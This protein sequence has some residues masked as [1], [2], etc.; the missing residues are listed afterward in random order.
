MKPSKVLILFSLFFAANNVNCQIFTVSGYIG[1][2]LTKETLYNAYIINQVNNTVVLSNDKGYYSLSAEKGLISLIYSY[3]GYEPK[4]L[5][6]KIAK[7]TLVDIYLVPIKIKEVTV[8][9]NAEPLFKQALLGKTNFTIKEIESI[10][11]LAGEPDLM[12]SIT[13]IAGV[14]GGREGYSNIY[15]RGGDRGQNLILL[16]GVKLYNTNHLGGFMSLFNSDIIKSVDIY[17]GGF[18]AGY[19]G[20]ASSVIYIQSREGNK[21]KLSGKYS[22]GILQSKV[23]LEGPIKSDKTSFLFALRGSYLDILTLPVRIKYLNGQTNSILGYT[24]TDLNFKLTQNVNNKRKLTLGIYSGQ[25]LM[26][27]IERGKYDLTSDKM[28]IVNTAIYLDGTNIIGAKLFSKSQLI[29]SSYRNSYLVSDE[30]ETSVENYLSKLENKSHLNEVSYK[31]QLSWYPANALNIRGGFEASVY[32]FSPSEFHVRQND[33]TNNISFDTIY[34][35]QNRLRSLESSLYLESELDVSNRFTINTGLRATYYRFNNHSDINL[36]PRLSIRMLIAEKLSAKASFT[37]MTQNNL[38]LISNY[39]GFEREVWL[40]ATDALPG[41]N[42]F[43]YSIGIFGDFE[44]IHLEYGIEAYIKE[45]SE[46]YYFRAPAEVFE[47]FSQLQNYITTGGTGNSV[48][49]EITAMFNYP[50]LSVSLAYTLAKTTRR[51]KDINNN[52]EFPS[53]FDRRHDLSLQTSYIISKKYILNAHFIYSSGT[54][55]T[56]PESYSPDN[57][58]YY[59]YFNYGEMNNVRLPDYHRLDFGLERHGLTR[60]GRKKKFTINIY[61]AYARQNPVYIYQNPDNGRTYQKSL[62]SF[63]PTISYSVEF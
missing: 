57:N 19:G 11:S 43:Q 50:K 28:N 5:T 10:P 26:S 62:I 1:D 3:V 40:P 7:D 45:L 23:L 59:G 38:A 56:F 15:V 2:S 4:S 21:T 48:G 16:D 30:L 9:A 46:M 41:Q 13:H 27:A 36:E 42:A 20:R 31:N 18:P 17:K 29:Y 37:K 61:N 22:I 52:M 35:I 25:D 24:F 63:L 51:F 8:T 32:G 14:S 44:K 58:F 33:Y 54:P 12:K 39:E 34:G 55:F 60:K 47:D 53:D 6:F 49:T